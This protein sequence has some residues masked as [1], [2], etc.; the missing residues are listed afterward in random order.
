M[1]TK[2]L[3]L[4]VAGVAVGHLLSTYLRKRREVSLETIASTTPIEPNTPVVDQAKIDKCNKEASDMMMRSKFGK[5]SDL[6]AIKKQKFDDCM[7]KSSVK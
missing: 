3:F 4:L 6:V 1:N 2:D 5:G 7:S